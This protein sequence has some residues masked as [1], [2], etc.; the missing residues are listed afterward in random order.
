[1]DIVADRDVYAVVALLFAVGLFALVVER[2]LMRKL[3]GLVLFQAG[4]FVFFIAGAQRDGATVP[5]IDAES[6]LDA[7]AYADPLPHLLVLTA[8]VVGAAIV[9]VAA[10]LLIR[11]NRAY[12]TLDDAE[13]SQLPP[14][15]SAGAEQVEPA[16][17]AESVEEAET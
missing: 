5:V 2:H 15:G 7:R 6:G 9:G 1:M 3:F 13:L 8:L 12:G 4:I 14:D 10:A 17:P 11:I 16:E